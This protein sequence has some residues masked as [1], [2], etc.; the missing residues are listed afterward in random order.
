MGDPFLPYGRHLI[1]DDDIAAVVAALRSGWLT[2]G[3]AVQAFEQAI[4]DKVGA[5][6]AV[7]CTSGTAALHLA[8]LALGLGPEDRIVVPTLT[9]LATANIGRFVGAEVAFADVDPDTGLTAERHVRAAL[10]RVPRVKAVIP[11]HLN[12]QCAP[13]EDIAGLA[14]AR[15]LSVIE[16]A[17]HAIGAVYRSSSGEIIRVGSCRHSAMTVFSFHPVKTV[18]MGEGG[19][20]TTNDRQLYERLVLLRSHGMT[21]DADMFEHGDLAFDVDGGAN[22]WYYEMAELGYNYR[23]SDVN[24]ALGLSQLSKLDRF[25]AKRRALVERYDAQLA[26][27]APTVRPLGRVK[28]CEPAWHLYVALIDFQDAGVS[29]AAVMR[30]LKADGIGTQVHYLPVHLQ[31]Y[32]RRRYGALQLPGAQEYYARCLS[33]PLHVNMEPSDVERV[34]DRLS[35]ALAGRP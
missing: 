31:P 32:Y 17:C 19:V 1:E 29:R 14:A 34:V 11:V 20:V 26:G 2:T 6:Y 12:G 5:A 23:A 24:C 21:H 16:D 13:M 18:T 25:V 3:P 22:P 10:E 27:L 33:L 7:S 28:D 15:G 8:A 30:R 9:F 35:K 4:A